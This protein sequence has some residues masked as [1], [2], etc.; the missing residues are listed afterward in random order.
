MR[1]GEQ[2]LEDRGRKPAGAAEVGLRNAARGSCH[3]RTAATDR[4]IVRVIF[5]PVEKLEIESG[6]RIRQ[7]LKAMRGGEKAMP[8]V[9]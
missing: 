4:A 6:K 1:G 9:H 5:R 3:A 2:A 8:T 7:E